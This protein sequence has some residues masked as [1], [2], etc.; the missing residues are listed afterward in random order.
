[1]AGLLKPAA[2]RVLVKAL[3]EEVGLPIHFHTHDTSGIAAA[4]DPRR[5]RG[6]GRRGGRGDGRASRATPRS[7]AS[8]RSSR[9][10]ATP[11]ATPGSTSRRSAQISDYWEAVR[12]AVRRLRG[13]AEG[14]GLGGLPARDAGRAVHQPQGAGALDGARG[15]L[16]RGGAHVRRGEPDV[17]RHREG[18]ALVQGRRRHGADDGGAGPDPRAGRGS[19]RRGRL[20]RERRR[21]D[22]GQ[23]RPAAGRLAAG[24]AE[25]DAEGRG[26]LDRAARAR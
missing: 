5:R 25:E 17:R 23:P 15:A 24:A 21:H 18:H 6:R 13:R 3:K 7:P 19:G 2:A 11:S 22:E 26:R 9:R 4:S 8:A 10:C 20:P 14:A 1:M 12:G 16:A